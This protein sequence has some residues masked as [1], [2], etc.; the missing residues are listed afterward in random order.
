MNTRTYGNEGDSYAKK[1]IF[2]EVDRPDDRM[3]G[4]AFNFR[5]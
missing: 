5:L 1:T 4:I 2:A 3:W